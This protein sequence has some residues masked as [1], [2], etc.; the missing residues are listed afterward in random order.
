MTTRNTARRS[1]QCSNARAAAAIPSFVLVLTA[2]ATTAFATEL[3]LE[4]GLYDLA[5]QM[6]MPHMDEMRRIVTHSQRC[7][8][9]A[10]PDAIFPVLEQPA[11]GGCVLGYPKLSAERNDYVLVCESARVASGTATLVSHADLMVGLLTVKMGGKNMTF[12][13]RVEA[14]RIG[15][16]PVG[17]ASAPQS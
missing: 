13:Q 3:T 14:R 10:A 11:L 8:M 17:G 1:R 7:L 4:P 15:P 16:C 9:T 5:E 12:S 2:L 6:V